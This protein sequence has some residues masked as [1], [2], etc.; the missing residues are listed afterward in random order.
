MA[1]WQRQFLGMFLAV[2]VTAPGCAKKADGL[3]PTGLTI[4]V[5]AAYPGADAKTVADAVAAPVEEQVR[6]V[7]KARVLASRCTNDGKYTLLVGFEAGADPDMAQVLV[8]NRVALAVPAM[9]AV[10]QSQGITVRK[11]ASGPLLFVTL[12]SPDASRDVRFLGNYA[13]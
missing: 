6:G 8:Q 1:T 10:V 11:R 5:E 12:T 7:E 4:V 13:R 2:L 9:P 3:S